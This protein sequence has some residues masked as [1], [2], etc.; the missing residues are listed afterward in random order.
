MVLGIDIGARFLRMAVCD[1]EGEVHA[2]E[3]VEH[4]G[5]DVVGVLDSAT[6]SAVAA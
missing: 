2:R 1:L 4:G 5:A 3:D 6:G